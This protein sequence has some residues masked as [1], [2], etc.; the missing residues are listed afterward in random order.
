MTTSEKTRI[1]T[2]TSN[3]LVQNAVDSAFRS[4]SDFEILDPMS[5]AVGVLQ[6]VENTHPD[7]ILLDFEYKLEETYDLVDKIASRFP[8]VAVIVIL[9]ESKVQFSDR[10]ILSGAR[11]FIL[12]PFTQKSIQVTTR[13]VLELLTRNYPV[14][15]L[16]EAR[17]QLP[18]P[19][20]TYVV[21][22]PK[23]GA[24]VSTVAVNLAIAVSQK[25][26][27]KVLLLDG[28]QMF[29]HVALMLNLRTANSITDLISHAGTLDPHLIN[30]VVIDHT[31]GIK[32]LPSPTMVAEGQGIRPDDLY[33]VVQGI[34]S[35]FPITVIDAGSFLNENTVTLM[36]AADKV[37]VVLNP[38]LA[39]LRDVR[40]F[41]DITRNLSYPAEKLMFVLN[42][43]GYKAE[44]RR[45]E[46]ESILKVKVA[47]S[48]PVDENLCLSCLNEGTPLML[49]SPRHPISK[50]I[51]T[52]AA[53]VL[54]QISEANAAYNTAEKQLS[55][56]VIAKSSRLG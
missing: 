21:Y 17:K 7:I 4:D 44:I 37:V 9:P 47:G 52:I 3:S 5:V 16:P 48:I 30:Q 46:I 22:S 35:T 20:N 40:Q 39:A 15:P 56:E 43:T 19:R 55:A 11:A 53:T 26:K 32:V 28:K 12:Y 51:Q 36:D 23:G 45:E 25:T 14:T 31:S 8:G 54:K 33:K 6:A 27:D 2:I 49:K 10:V 34:Q 13:R 41:M 50:A 1:L 29:G 24:G 38:N 18:K 42:Q